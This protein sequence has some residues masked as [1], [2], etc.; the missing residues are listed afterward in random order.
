[1]YMFVRLM[2]S[3]L[4]PMLILND[5]SSIILSCCGSSALVESVVFM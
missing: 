5:C 4:G 3:S 2:C 1:M